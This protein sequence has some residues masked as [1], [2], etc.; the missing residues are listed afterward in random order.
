MNFVRRFVPLFP[1]VTAPLVQLTRTDFTTRRR[2]K[3]AR[4]SAQDIAFAHIK[5]L[6][7]WALVFNFLD[8][9]RDVVVHVNASELG[10]GAFL[11]QPSKNYDSKSDLDTIPYFCHRLKHGQRHYPRR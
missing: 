7:V 3:N 10:V 5:C 4:G 2:L 6:L 1:E 11:A 8:Y 9:E